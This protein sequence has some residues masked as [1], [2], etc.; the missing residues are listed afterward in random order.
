M[1]KLFLHILPLSLKGIIFIPLLL[2]IRYLIRRY[3]KIYTYPVWI[4]IFSGLIINI[5][6]PVA[7][8]AKSPLIAFYDNIADNIADFADDYQGETEIYYSGH[9]GFFR[10]VINDAPIQKENDTGYYTGRDF[11]VVQKGTYMPRLT[12]EDKYLPQMYFIWCIVAV[13]GFIWFTGS[14]LRIDD[15]LRNLKQYKDNIWFADNIPSP[16]VFGIVRPKIYIPSTLESAN[17]D[18]IILHEKTHIKHLDN[19]IKP[20]ALAIAI[21]HWFN[22]LVWLCYTLLCRDIEMACD[23]AVIRKTGADSKKRYS[24][25]LLNYS[26]GRFPNSAATVLFAQSDAEKRIKNILSYKKPAVVSVIVLT[27]EVMMCCILPFVTSE[28]EKRADKLTFTQQLE[29]VATTTHIPYR[30]R[31]QFFGGKTQDYYRYYFDTGINEHLSFTGDHRLFVD[32]HLKP[33]DGLRP[34]QQVT[35]NKISLVDGNLYYYC[36]INQRNSSFINYYMFKNGESCGGGGSAPDISTKRKVTEVVSC[37]L[38]AEDLSYQVFWTKPIHSSFGGDEHPKLTILKHSTRPLTSVEYRLQQF[39]LI[40]DHKFMKYKNIR[41]T[42]YIPFRRTGEFVT[43]AR[44]LN[45]SLGFITHHNG[46]YTPQPMAM[47]TVDGGKTW[48]DMDFASLLLPEKFTGYR[49]RFLHLEGDTIKIELDV[50]YTDGSYSE[51]M[52]FPYFLYSSDCGKTWAGYT[53]TGTEFEDGTL[54]YRHHKAT[55]TIAVKIK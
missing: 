49:S 19:L 37:D 11:V 35:G 41:E 15:S 1:E 55:D 46:D 54:I 4:I 6:L 13:S 44:F 51:K 9:E 27:V 45:E 36:Y 39:Q 5:S 43:G 12:A 22:P 3:P 21:I 25:E 33:V 26:E 23:E 30:T 42:F 47:V 20:A 29:Q 40:N 53:V 38:L 48:L 31:T 28:T 2:G 16:F 34:H 32:E 8:T 24:M 7:E 52:E 10:A 50:Q 18:Y 14:Y 17:L